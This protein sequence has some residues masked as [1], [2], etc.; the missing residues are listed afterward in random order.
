MQQCLYMIQNISI[1]FTTLSGI[2][3]FLWIISNIKRHNINNV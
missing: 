2:R 3:W 1:K